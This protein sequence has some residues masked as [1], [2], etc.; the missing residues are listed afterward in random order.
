MKRKI[1]AL[2]MTAA[3]S[4]SLLTTPAFAAEASFKDA[5]GHWAEEAI[6]AVVEK[7][8][9]NGTSED[10]FSPDLSMNRGMFVTVL[11]RF[12]EGMGYQMS[13]TPAFTDVSESVYYAP[14]V[15]WASANGVVNGVG[16]GKFAPNQDVTREQMCALFVRFLNYVGYKVPAGQELTFT[17]TASISSYA[18]EPVKTALALGLIQG[19]ETADGQMAFNPADSATRAQVATVFLRLDRVEGIHDLKPADA[20][21]PVTPSQSE[22]Q[23]PTPANTD[24]AQG[25][26]GGGAGGGGGGAATPS[27]PSKPSGPDTTGLTLAQ[28]TTEAKIAETL[29]KIVDTYQDIGYYK[30][31]DPEVKSV[32]NILG[33]AIRSALKDRA[34]GTPLTKAYVK[35]EYTDEMEEFKTAYKALSKTHQDDV[36]NVVARL[37]VDTQDLKDVLSYF[38]LKVSDF[39]S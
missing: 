4:L 35:Q 33:N 29:T 34:N 6:N 30:T 31:A 27:T 25:G 12:A 11:G 17:D 18:V 1:C 23:T 2:A 15:A 8:L 28:I 22:N 26:G 13:G 14:Y 36:F 3:I 24:P 32:V 21:E 7:K 39:T 5:S 9:F 19:V 10:T 37:D 38:G 20:V 16:D